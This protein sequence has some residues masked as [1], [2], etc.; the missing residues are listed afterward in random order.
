MLPGRGRVAARERR[1][2]GRD[3]VVPARR[4]AARRPGHGPRD[5][6]LHRPR[7]LDRA[8]RRVRGPRLAGGARGSTMLA[9]DVSSL[10][11]AGS[12]WTRPATGS[13]PPSTVR[14]ARSA[15]PA[16]SSRRCRRSAWRSASGIHTGEC[17]R[18]GD[19]LAGF[20]VNIGAR[21]AAA[22]GPARSFVSGTVRDLVA[23]SGFA[24]DDLGEHELKG[25]P[26]SWRLL[27]VVA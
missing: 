11:S 19:K 3:R 18:V 13:S 26:G 7:R 10:A 21:V 22:A 23:G 9:C 2:A 8:R 16:R 6:A 5:R 17:E 1:R 14:H 20:A 25:V 4:G 24:F 27:R 15:A 12:S